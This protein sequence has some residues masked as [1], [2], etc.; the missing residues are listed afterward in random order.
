MIV[1][2]ELA[3]GRITGAHEIHG[4]EDAYIAQLAPHG[5]GGLRLGI[6]GNV[7]Y[8][9]GGAIRPRPDS[10]IAL[11][12][13]TTTTGEPVTLSGVPRG[14]GIGIAG[15]IAHRLEATGGPLQFSFAL[16]G[17]YEFQI[18]AFPAR[19]AILRVSV[20]A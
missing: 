18:D 9:D 10:G 15:P 6:D 1:T 19:D 8:V 20:E 12:K 13:T 3:T 11:D 5:Q 14:A 2:Y 7:F 16:P 17:V 4:N